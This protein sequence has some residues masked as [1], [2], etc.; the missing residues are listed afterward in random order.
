MSDEYVLIALE[1][2][3]VV[4]GVDA[5]A[6]YLYHWPRAQCDV[7]S[8]ES[9]EEAAVLARQVYGFQFY[10]H[11]KSFALQPMALPMTAPFA[12][13]APGEARLSNTKYAFEGEQSM[14]APELHD[15]AMMEQTIGLVEHREPI[16][17]GNPCFQ[18]GAWSVVGLDGYAVENRLENVISMLSG[19]EFLYPHAK[20]WAN[21]SH[22]SMWA[23]R[24]YAERFFRRYDARDFQ[25][26]RLERQVSVGEQ[27]KDEIYDSRENSRVDY[28]VM[29]KLREIGFI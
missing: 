1:N 22:A 11:P 23:Q 7:Y 4:E 24:E 15:V 8:L 18:G 17:E 26:T 6:S 20:W 13:K 21:P 5:L 16:P 12:I 10:S 27:F 29:Q 28:A 2:I 3:A 14:Q 9:T 19:K 25:F